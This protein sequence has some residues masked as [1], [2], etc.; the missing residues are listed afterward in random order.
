M[1]YQASIAE[2]MGDADAMD[3]F[4]HSSEL[5]SHVSMLFFINI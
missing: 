2:I 5:G 3:L 1:F 4:R